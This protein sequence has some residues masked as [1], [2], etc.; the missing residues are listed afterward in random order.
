MFSYN[1]KKLHRYYQYE[2]KK[3]LNSIQEA[4]YIVYEYQDKEADLWAKLE[5]KYGIPVQEPGAYNDLVNA[6]EEAAWE[7]AQA[8]AEEGEEGGEEGGGG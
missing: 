7:A 2:V 6:D 4:R 3:K 1:T 8:A 5:K